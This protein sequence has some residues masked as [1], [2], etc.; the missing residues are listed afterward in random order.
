MVLE[1]KLNTDDTSFMA[2]FTPQ[3][4]D[5]I[6]NRLTL[7]DIVGRRVTYDKRKSQPQKGDFWACCP[8][9]NEKTPSFHVDDRRNIYH[10]FGCGVTGDH[11]RFLTEKEGL[12][13]PEA[14]ERLADEAGV[15]LPKLDPHEVEQAKKRGSL[16]DVVAFAQQ[17]FLEQLQGPL[18]AAARGYLQQRGLSLETQRHFGIG[19]APR[20]R[21]TLKQYLVSKGVE[22]AQM[23]EAGLVVAGPDIPVSYD[24]FRDRIMFPILD[25]R[26]RVIAFGGRAMSAD[27]PAKYMNSPETPL[28]SKRSVLYNAANARKVAYDRKRIVVVEGY[29]D[30]IALAQAGIPEAVAPLGTALTGEQL[31]LLWK[32]ADEPILCFDGDEAG[33]RAANRSV[34]VALPLLKPGKTV[35]FT[36]LPD[37]QDPDDLINAEG[38]E[39]V[40]E[41]LNDARSLSDLIWVREAESGTFDTPE[42]KAALEARFSDL[43]RSIADQNVRRHYEQAFRDKMQAFFSPNGV[44]GQ[45]GGGYGGN[46]GYGQNNYGRQYNKSG[47]GYNRDFSNRRGGFNGGRSGRNNGPMITDR[48][49]K[50]PLTS[51]NYGRGQ[52]LIPREVVL[53]ATLMNHPELLGDY[54]ES[55][56]ELSFKNSVLAKLQ[57]GLLSSV[58][59]GHEFSAS[60]LRLFLVREGLE[61]EVFRIEAAVNGLHM[62]QIGANAPVSSAEM[63]YKQAQALHHRAHTLHKELKAA[64]RAYAN[65]ESELN[66]ERLLDVNAQIVSVDE[67][68]VLLGNLEDMP[69]G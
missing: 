42:R 3:I 46:S 27:N 40:E 20:D 17:F 16:Y 63:G 4:L 18:G 51:K 7:S 5:E 44:G 50:N 21:S 53:V 64:E 60:E 1:T 10:C 9:H 31:H 56:S 62:W 8:F 22:H 48:L 36:M 69:N 12:S 68:D 58:A 47:G 26:E 45:S 49:R 24:K 43:I 39:A 25:L 32:I 14:V 34:D 13:F 37:G 11:F 41:L 23:V 61:D 35:Q 30:V 67:D 33:Q 19:F 29:M 2:R 54:F 15:E 57:S 38:I 52:P 28:F 6:R 66:L 55:F 59:V 65:D